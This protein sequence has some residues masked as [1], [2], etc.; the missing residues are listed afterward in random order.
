[1]W[2]AITGKLVTTFAK[3]HGGAPVTSVQWTKN[4]KYLLSMG[5]DG[6]G[7]LWDVKGEKELVEFKGA[8]VGVGF[9]FC[10]FLCGFLRVDFV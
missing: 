9:S 2:D 5:R 3:A 7:R 1:M 6:V 4:G 10:C 8:E